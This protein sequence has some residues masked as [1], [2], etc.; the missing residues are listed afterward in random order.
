MIITKK[1]SLPDN[2]KAVL[3]DMDGVLVDSIDAWYFIINDTLNHFGLA[4]ISRAKFEKRFGASIENDVK[5]LYIGK[6]IKEVELAYNLNF[7]KRKK[8]VRIFPNSE[9]VLKNLKKKK[10]KLGL[11]T[12]STE[13]ITM[14]ILEHIKIKKYFDVILTMNDVRR[15]KPAPDMVL[16]AC[17]KL[18]INPENAIVVGDTDNDMIAGKRAGCVTVGYMIKG[19]YGINRLKEIEK[20]I[21]V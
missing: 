14:E 15:R 16:K 21:Y 17:R 4:S 20:F 3:W 18:K 10:L 6:S 1:L 5:T 8:Y 12:N 9:L 13:K 11:L 7:K 2:I 19:D